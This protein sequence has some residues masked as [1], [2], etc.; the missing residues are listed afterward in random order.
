MLHSFLGIPE[1]WSTY[2]LYL[3]QEDTCHV[4][5]PFIIVTLLCNRVIATSLIWS[6]AGQHYSL[7]KTTNHNIDGAGEW[8][9]Q[10]QYVRYTIS[11]WYMGWERWKFVVQFCV[12]S[13]SSNDVR[14]GYTCKIVEIGNNHRWSRFKPI[15]HP[16]ITQHEILCVAERT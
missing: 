2:L 1:E 12:R 10:Q 6:T 3:L 16:R 9:S 13:W 11:L 4:L 15:K 14:P 8:C 5:K 7:P